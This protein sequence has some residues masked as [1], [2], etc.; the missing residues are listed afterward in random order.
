M[1][2][3]FC[4]KFPNFYTQVQA[5]PEII[6]LHKVPIHLNTV[7][8][9]FYQRQN[10]LRLEE[11]SAAERVAQ[12]RLEK[13]ARAERIAISQQALKMLR[14]ELEPAPYIF[15]VIPFSEW[16]VFPVREISKV[17]VTFLFIY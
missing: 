2:N 3:C 11:E 10:E 16:L 7:V 17:K 12:L 8:F 5:K 14:D 15:D 6:E 9:D 1:G 4:F 13:E